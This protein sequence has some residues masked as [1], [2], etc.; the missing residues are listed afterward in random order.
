ME[1]RAAVGAAQLSFMSRSLRRAL[2]R[3]GSGARGA[4]ALSVPLR[5]AARRGSQARGGAPS[6]V[7]YR[8]AGIGR[9]SGASRSGERARRGD[10]GSSA[11]AAGA[12]TFN[13]EELEARVK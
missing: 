12:A 4:L 3:A 6:R 2:G 7:R 11:G 10:A 5:S 13:V 8:S 9:G 1:Q